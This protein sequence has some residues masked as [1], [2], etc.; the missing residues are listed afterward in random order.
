MKGMYDNMDVHAAN[1]AHKFRLLA[2]AF[3]GIIQLVNEAFSVITGFTP[4]EVVGRTPVIL[5]SGQ[6]DEEFYREYWH[7]LKNQGNWQGEIWNRRKSGEIYPEGLSVTSV[8]DSNKQITNFVAVFSDISSQK[9]SEKRLQLFAQYNVITGLPNLIQKK[10]KSKAD[11]P[12]YA[13]KGT[14]L[15][16]THSSGPTASVLIKNPSQ[17]RSFTEENTLKNSMSLPLPDIGQCFGLKFIVA[18]VYDY[19]VWFLMAF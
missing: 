14:N 17:P 10:V 15:P 18:P 5:K 4:E 12:P 2:K 19:F 8:K 3:N 11:K 9:L 1:V 16:N 13:L 6:H 7:S